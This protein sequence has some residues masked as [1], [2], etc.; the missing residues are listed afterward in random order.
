MRLRCWGESNPSITHFRYNIQFFVN[1]LFRKKWD[2]M[3][4]WKLWCRTL[5]M[6]SMEISEAMRGLVFALNCYLQVVKSAMDRWNWDANV[7]SSCIQVSVPFLTFIQSCKSYLSRINGAR[8]P[9]IDQGI[10]EEPTCSRDM[11]A[12]NSEN[13]EQVYLAQASTLNKPLPYEQIMFLGNRSNNV[14]R[15]CGGCSLRCGSGVILVL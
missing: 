8:D 9:F 7:T 2:A 4:M 1:F 6:C 14:V 10:L 11:C 15:S 13:S 3:S 5:G 12:S